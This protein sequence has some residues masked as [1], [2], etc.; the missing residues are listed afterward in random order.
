VNVG[1]VP[2]FD[3][4]WKNQEACAIYYYPVQWMGLMMLW[5]GITMKMLGMLAK[6]EEHEETDCA[7][8]Y[9]ANIEIG[10]SDTNW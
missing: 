6:S 5:G 10:E 2:C 1:R 3:P 4:S 7:G 8:G 9:S